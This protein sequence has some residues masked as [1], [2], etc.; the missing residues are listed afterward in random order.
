MT[1]ALTVGGADSDLQKRLEDELT[2]F[3]LRATRTTEIEDYTVAIR[4]EA[5]ELVAGLTGWVWR[6]CGG[7]SLIWVR[8]DQ[9]GAG[10]GSRLLAAAE[11]EVVRRG[12]DRIILSSFTFQAPD[13]YRRNGYTET[14][15]WPGFPTGAEDVH[16]T[17]QLA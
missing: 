5:G 14:G 16:F 2:A 17:K 12:C 6:D 8:E 1:E 3:N 11:Q 15:R 4:D 10:H 9:R 13:F 7:V